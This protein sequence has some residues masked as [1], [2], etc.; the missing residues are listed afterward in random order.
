MT[1]MTY[2]SVSQKSRSR[3][4]S[5]PIPSTVT[6]YACRAP[7]VLLCA[8]QNLLR[9]NKRT[10]QQQPHRTTT[11]ALH[12]Q[13]EGCWGACCCGGGAIGLL[14]TIPRQLHVQGNGTLIYWNRGETM[15]TKRKMTD[16][17]YMMPALVV[18]FVL[19]VSA[20]LIFVVVVLMTDEGQN[21]RKGN[22]CDGADPVHV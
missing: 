3:L 21:E 16:A 10:A 13:G 8:F 9:L 22:D 5:P 15:T 1:Y 20:H 18:V 4:N 17:Y 19:V 7:S 14:T 11:T 6:N 2:K 12:N